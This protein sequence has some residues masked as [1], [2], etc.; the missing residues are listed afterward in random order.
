MLIMLISVGNQWQRYTLAYTYGYNGDDGSIQKGNPKYEIKTEYPDIV[1]YYGLLSGIAFA[2]SYSIC[3]IFAGVLSDKVNRKILIAVACVLWSTCTLLTGLIDSFAVLFVMRFLL[4]FFESAFNPCAYGIIADYFH[5]DYRTTANSIFNLGIYLG[6]ALSSLSIL[7]ISNLGW[8]NTFK[9]IGFI[10]IGSGVAGFFFIAEPKRGKFEKKEEK[11]AS[12]DP[13][14]DKVQALS[15]GA[16]FLQAAGEIFVNPTC[17]Y[18]TIAAALR[19]FAGYAIGFFMPSYFGKV[20]KSYKKEYAI[21]NAVVVSLCGLTS[22]LTGGILSDKYEKK[23]YFMTKS[24]ICMIGTFGGIPTIMLCC[25]VQNNFW[26]SMLGLGL[27]Y[28]IAECWIGPAITM[29]LNT[30]SPDNKGYAVSAFLFFA[31]V[32]GTISTWLLGL[33]Q[34]K[35]QAKENPQYYGY[36]LC[37]F[38]TV[39]YGLSIPFFYLA[40]KTYTSHK[41][42]EQRK[43]E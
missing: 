26:I 3:G 30:I 25:L 15:P 6:G 5:P 34:E 38:V 18:T 43:K 27:E 39:A 7:M 36:I 20:Y 1:S 42:E 13:Q 35:Y 21:A 16:Q 33:L 8:R 19:F 11:P 22:S 23:G 14:E 4:G 24:Y 9:I 12:F 32:A 10:G 31:T 2:A 29:V 40:G 17:R 37:I 28:L 41:L